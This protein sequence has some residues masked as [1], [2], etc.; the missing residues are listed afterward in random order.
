[1]LSQRR[2][3]RVLYDVRISYRGNGDLRRQ[4]AS[5]VALR[6][7]VARCGRGVCVSADGRSDVD[8]LVD[9]LLRYPDRDGPTRKP[10]EE[11]AARMK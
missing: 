8:P 3:Q 5:I 9:A 6:Q 10:C 1:M 7:R 2:G 11:L 4:N